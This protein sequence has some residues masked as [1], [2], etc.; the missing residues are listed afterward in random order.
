[1]R[2][3]CAAQF[4]FIAVLMGQSIAAFMQ[5]KA[6]LQLALSCTVVVTSHT[7]LFVLLLRALHAQLM[8]ALQPNP[9]QDKQECDSTMLPVLVEGLIASSFLQP[10]LIS[11]CEGL[12]DADS[13]ADELQVNAHPFTQ[14]HCC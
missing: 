3:V 9:Q 1:M 4:A 7:Q 11:F 8:L 12:Q 5:W 10:L 6:I 14:S 13:M 2:W